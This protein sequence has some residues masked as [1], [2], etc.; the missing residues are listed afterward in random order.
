MKK[1]KIEKTDVK[2]SN[3]RFGIKTVDDFELDYTDLI[4]VALDTPPQG[5][6][7]P[8]DI[9]ERNRIQKIMDEAKDGVISFEDADWEN[10]KKII[11]ASRWMVR[12]K[13][14]EKFLQLFEDKE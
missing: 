3:V 5:G 6:F 1:F 2:N 10:L 7:I 9:R 8:K 12:N 11:K 4:E 13:D 14:L